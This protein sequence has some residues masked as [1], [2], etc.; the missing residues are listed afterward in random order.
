MHVIFPVRDALVKFDEVEGSLL[1][2]SVGPTL[3]MQTKNPKQLLTKTI[4]PPVLTFFS[5]PQ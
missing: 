2:D 4:L 5:A 3:A 1:C